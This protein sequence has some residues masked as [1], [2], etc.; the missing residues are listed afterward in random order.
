VA[1]LAGVN[2]MPWRRF[3]FWNALGGIVWSVVFGTLGY[4]LGRNLPL[5]DRILGVLGWGGVVAALGV[6]AVAAGV[7]IWRRR[8]AERAAVAAANEPPA[9]AE[10]PPVPAGEDM[11]SDGV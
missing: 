11:A 8:V 1:F 6:V 5:L 10:P 4:T 9:D 2:H 7:V 3:L